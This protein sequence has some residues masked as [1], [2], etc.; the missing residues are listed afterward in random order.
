[1]PCKLSFLKSLYSD[2]SNKSL[3]L[4]TDRPVSKNGC[5]KVRH[6]LKGPDKRMSQVMWEIGLR[7]TNEPAA[8]DK[9]Y[10]NAKVK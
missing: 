4:Y 10:F 2:P 5:Q 3:P 7:G 1:V 6:L 9:K 8:G